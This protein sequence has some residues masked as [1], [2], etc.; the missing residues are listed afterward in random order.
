MNLRPVVAAAIVDSLTHPTAL[1]CA[2]RAYPEELRG[3]FELPGGKIEPGENP[4]DALL[5][6]IREELSV[7]ITLGPEVLTADGDWW[8]ILHDRRMGVWLAEITPTS[9][10]RQDST[11]PGEFTFD[12]STPHRFT[13]SV[14]H[15]ERSRSGSNAPQPPLV[16]PGDAHLELR[17]VA[18]SEVTD[19]NWIQA[20]FEIVLAVV[21]A[22]R[23]IH[24]R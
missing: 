19:L 22:C 20:D 24:Q 16:V 7:D 15:P 18:L 6:E 2:A 17:W 3:L 14:P 21:E 23:R 9:A 12:A 13:A 5:R 4:Q 10:P 1:L 8:P 11:T